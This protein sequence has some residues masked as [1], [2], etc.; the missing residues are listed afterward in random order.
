MMEEELT[1]DRREVFLKC[2]AATSNI[3]FSAERA[4]VPSEILFRE[5]AE[6]QAFADAWDCAVARGYVELEARLSDAPSIAT[7]TRSR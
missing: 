3:E 1:A 2:L 5:R 7:P 4:A 6:D